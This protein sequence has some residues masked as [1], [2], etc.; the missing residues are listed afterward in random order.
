MGESYTFLAGIWNTV[1][2]ASHFSF[3]VSAW[4]SRS[5]RFSGAELISQR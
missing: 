1:M 2:L 4:K 5:M 3:V